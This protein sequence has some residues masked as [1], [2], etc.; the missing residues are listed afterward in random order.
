MT[1]HPVV[2]STMVVHTVT[3]ATVA[4]G[5][6]LFSTMTVTFLPTTTAHADT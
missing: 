2:K 5:L 6:S 1:S 4:L 3:F